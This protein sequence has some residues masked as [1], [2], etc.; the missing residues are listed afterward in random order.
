VCLSGT[1]LVQVLLPCPTLQMQS[2]IGLQLV[3]VLRSAPQMTSLAVAGARLDDPF[4]DGLAFIAALPSAGH[5]QSLSLPAC[6]VNTSL[7]VPLAGVLPRLPCLASLDLS[8]NEIGA[9]GAFVLART[10][11]PH[12]PSLVLF[13]FD[14]NP[15]FAWQWQRQSSDLALG[16]LAAAN[17][18]AP[19]G[20]GAAGAVAAVLA[21]VARRQRS[22]PARERG[23]GT[24]GTGAA[25]TG[26]GGVSG[27][28]AAGNNGQV[29]D[30]VAF[31]APILAALACLEA[32][33][34]RY[35]WVKR[36][37]LIAAWVAARGPGL[38]TY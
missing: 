25:A 23:T 7:S 37:E 3:Q 33:L 18:N 34:P 11:L 21:L 38:V 20:G 31:Q 32:W 36:R 30:A 10:A 9:H 26:S 2:I 17:A 15:A 14:G 5:L 12:C 28:L 8:A 4:T 27:W 19:R 1:H 13:A 24:T 29:D 16:P 22:A 6:G 35:T